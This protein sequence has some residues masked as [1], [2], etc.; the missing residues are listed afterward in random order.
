MRKNVHHSHNPDTVLSFDLLQ[1]HEL[2]G[3]GLIKFLFV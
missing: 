2:D 1:I 3:I